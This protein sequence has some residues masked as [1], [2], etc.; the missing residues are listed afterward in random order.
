MP[1]KIT[2]ALSMPQ[3]YPIHVCPVWATF[4]FTVSETLSALPSVPPGNTW[5]LMSPLVRVSTVRANPSA[6]CFRNGPPPQAV[7]MLHCCAVMPAIGAAASAA[8]RAPPTS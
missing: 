6:S 3:S 1:A 7:A 4:D 5:I 8:P 2:V